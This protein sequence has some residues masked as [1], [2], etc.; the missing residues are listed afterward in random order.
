[1]LVTEQLM[2]HIASYLELP[3]ERVLEVNM[4]KGGD[5][6]PFGIVQ[7][8]CPIRRCWNTLKKKCSY[9]QRKVMVDNFNK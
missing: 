4:Y 5:V 1:M 2:S 3:R 7:V 8:V 6:T 9:D